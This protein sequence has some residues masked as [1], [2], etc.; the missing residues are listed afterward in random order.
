M[1]LFHPDFDQIDNGFKTSFTFDNEEEEDQLISWLSY[2]EIDHLRSKIPVITDG[3][4]SHQTCVIIDMAVKT[5]EEEE[6]VEDEVVQVEEETTSKKK[7]SKKVK[8][9]VASE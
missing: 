5:N 3:K 2:M 9:E 7:K 6:V 4:M 1:K 8:E